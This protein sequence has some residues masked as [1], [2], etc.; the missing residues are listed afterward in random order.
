MEK[1]K[2]LLQPDNVDYV[3]C[4]DLD[5]INGKEHQ[6]RVFSVRKGLAFLEGKNKSEMCAHLGQILYQHCIEKTSENDL[7]GSPFVLS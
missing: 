7:I 4:N 3:V 6:Y 1:L 5:F 2:P